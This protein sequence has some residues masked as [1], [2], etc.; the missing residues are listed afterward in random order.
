MVPDTRAVQ[1]TAGVIGGQDRTAV[2]HRHP[3]IDVQEC[4][5]PQGGGGIGDFSL[6]PGGAFIVGDQQ[7]P[8]LAKNVS[9]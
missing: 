9:D 6:R 8:L 2:A 4:H 7:Q 5:S 1:V 3:A